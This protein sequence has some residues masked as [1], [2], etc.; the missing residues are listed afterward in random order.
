MSRPDLLALD[1]DKLAALAN[2]GLVKRARKDL[3]G[4]DEYDLELAPDGLL[5]VTRDEIVT[6]LGPGVPLAETEC[7][8]G[9]RGAC[10]HRIFAVLAY[11]AG[12]GE[13]ESQVQ[14][15]DP[16]EFEDG[17]L[18]ELLGPGLM[19]RAR[20]QAT[21]GMQV[22][23]RRGEVP[24][25]LLPTCTVAFLVPNDLAYARCDCAQESA[26]E[27]I[28]LAVWGFRAGRSGVDRV[29][30]GGSGKGAEEVL[31]QARELVWSVL[32]SGVVHAPAELV[33]GLEKMAQRLSGA[34]LV[35]MADLTRELG[36]SL[37]SYRGRA[38]SYS[39]D[40]QARLVGEWLARR[41]A[42]SAPK[43]EL[44]PACVLGVGEPPETAL[45]HI[46]LS[47]LGA[48]V[49]GDADSHHVALYLADPDTSTVLV[50]SRR[51]PA[52]EVPMA[53][54]NILK[55]IRLDSLARGQLVTRAA[56][57]RA[58]R[59]LSIGQSRV[60]QHACYAQ[61]GDWEELFREP[62]INSDFALLRERL[63]A[64]GPALLRARVRAEQVVILVPESVEDLHYDSARQQV[65][66]TVLDAQ[67]KSLM[68]QSDFNPLA[69]TA[70][71]TLYTALESGVRYLS[72]HLEFQPEGLTVDPLAVVT[73][74]VI[75]PSLEPEAELPEMARLH[76]PPTDDPVSHALE[77]TQEV[78]SRGSHHGLSYLPGSWEQEA[79]AVSSELKEVGLVRLGRDLDALVQERG[80]PAWAT[81]ASRL[82]L[83]REC[84]LRGPSTPPRGGECGP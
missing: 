63:R 40:Q 15:W 41:R 7:S 13:N 33:T 21:R 14:A 61:S 58:N 38:A 26:C 12:G 47:S 55:G 42:A 59:S 1:D 51:W 25:A 83:T 11:Q 43:A 82:W 10:R 76:C 68:L 50:L 67:G 20:T 9:A 57:R 79:R 64:Q 27:H 39:S 84:Y 49:W 8:C 71:E 80:G 6:R 45:E 44:S 77:R 75:V 52:G 65:R 35:W 18:E 78:V 2:R 22:Q 24:T 73:E 3:A 36:Q 62:L 69:P 32:E 28:A 46:R 17:A 81:L 30:L 23:L 37:E 29:E 54:R 4:G 19:R 66:A 34:G 5:T 70:L 56:K 72:G 16:A 53:R 60:A 48:R 31:D 74:K